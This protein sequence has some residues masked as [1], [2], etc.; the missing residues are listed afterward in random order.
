MNWI[1]FFTYII[2]AIASLPIGYFSAEFAYRKPKLIPYMVGI[3]ILL[4]GLIMGLTS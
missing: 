2:I 4:F 1:A 3:M